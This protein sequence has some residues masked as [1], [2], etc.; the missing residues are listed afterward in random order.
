MYQKVSTDLNFVDREKN[1]EKFWRENDI[2]K[3]YFDTYVR[4]DH[5]IAWSHIGVSEGKYVSPDKNGYTKFDIYCVK[6][7][8]DQFCEYYAVPYGETQIE[9]VYIFQFDDSMVPVWIKPAN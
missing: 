6:R 9:T 5:R 7:S 3:T 1:I 8:Y 4:D 2:F